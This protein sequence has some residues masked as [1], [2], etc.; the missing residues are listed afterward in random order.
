M[1]LSSKEASTLYLMYA[2]LIYDEDG[3]YDTYGQSWSSAAQGTGRG[4]GSREQPGPRQANLR[5]YIS[6]VGVVET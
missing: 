3:T 5:R 6:L 1:S 4:A 2:F